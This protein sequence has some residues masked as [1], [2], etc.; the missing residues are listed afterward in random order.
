MAISS[1]NP[2]IWRFC[3]SDMGWR[4]A[5]VSDCR[6]SAA[7][8]CTIMPLLGST[9]SKIGLPF[10]MFHLAK[11]Q[12]H[13]G[14]HNQAVIKIDQHRRALESNWLIK[15]TYGVMPRVSLKISRMGVPSTEPGKANF[16]I[17][18]L[19][20]ESGSEGIDTGL[21]WEDWSSGKRS[22]WSWLSTTIKGRG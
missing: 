22:H 7:R 3:P 14:A 15:R 4:V 8:A 21:L 2:L 10:F 5:Q 1:T 20:F 19:I 12:L 9:K 17:A 6:S 16:K 11:P 13:Q 18:R